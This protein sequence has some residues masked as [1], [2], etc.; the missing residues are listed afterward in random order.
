[1]APKPP[2]ARIVSGSQGSSEFAAVITTSGRAVSCSSHPHLSQHHAAASTPTKFNTVDSVREWVPARGTSTIQTI[3]RSV[4]ASRCG[5]VQT[6]RR[7]PFGVDLPNSVYSDGTLIYENTI[8]TKISVYAR[9][10]AW[11]TSTLVVIIVADT[12]EWTPATMSDI[13]RGEP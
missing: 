10:L 8:L 3:S 11:S 4:P 5:G 12:G 7:R 6:V 9:V 13:G 1:M 2:H